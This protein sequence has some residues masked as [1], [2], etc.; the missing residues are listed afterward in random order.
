MDCIDTAHG[1]EAESGAGSLGSFGLSQVHLGGLRGAGGDLPA[2]HR[3]GLR[4]QRGARAEKCRSA[5]VLKPPARKVASTWRCSENRSACD[6]SRRNADLLPKRDL[7]RPREVLLVDDWGEL[8]QLEAPVAF[9]MVRQ[10]GS[11]LQHGDEV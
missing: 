5:G 11:R 1:V 7:A 10:A 2:Q 6:S 4:V 3:P 9:S 8:L